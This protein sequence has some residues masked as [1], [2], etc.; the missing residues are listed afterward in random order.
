MKKLFAIFIYIISSP[1]ISLGQSVYMHEA[2]EDARES[3]AIGFSGI[4]S[5]IIFFGII[6]IISKIYNNYKENKEREK[7]LNEER[8]INLKF[9]KSRVKSIL[10]KDKEVSLLQNNKSWQEGFEEAYY[11]LHFGRI[12]QEEKSLL[13]LRNEL[14]MLEITNPQSKYIAYTYPKNER[15]KRRIGYLEYIEYNKRQIAKEKE[16][17]NQK[18]KENITLQNQGSTNFN[19]I[20]TPANPEVVSKESTKST[21]TTKNADSNDKKI[22]DIL[23]T[24][25]IKV[26]GLV[27][28]ADK[29]TILKGS[30]EGKVIVP[31]G[32]EIVKGDAF[33]F[34][35]D[36]KEIVLPDSVKI[37]EDNAFMMT[38]IEKIKMPKYLT[39]LGTGVFWGCENLKEIELSEG[40][41]LL[42]QDTFRDCMGLK[43]VKLPS[44]LISIGEGAFE[45]CMSLETIEIPNG[46][47][48]IGDDAFA[49]CFELKKIEL[50]SS[51][52]RIGLS[53]FRACGELKEFVIPADV[54]GISEYTF[55]DCYNLEK[56]K[57]KGF[58]GCLLKHAFGNCS[59]MT[60][61]MPISIKILGKDVFSQCD[62][63]RIEVPE[64]KKEWYEEQLP[65]YKDR[66]IT[67][68][69]NSTFVE[70]PE[71]NKK[72]ESFIGIH[73]YIVKKNENELWE[74][75]GYKNN[76]ED[77]D[78]MYFEDDDF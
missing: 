55:Y 69:D 64:T 63:I 5:V 11:D 28:S 59:K 66:I 51:V 24:N 68:K 20:N 54:I 52:N 67:Y 33:N 41:T 17:K 23:E 73:D 14:T 19:N 49:G 26:K 50:P 30:G 58:P 35:K 75:M 27:I 34:N 16:L 48:N 45:G 40:L 21:N 70:T 9:S 74:S 6:Y 25:D 65:E 77:D 57:F 72:L 22:N 2:Q 4:I 31:D 32:V 78:W 46:V 53:S 56:V 8:E 7:K 43:Y 62:E 60:I 71:W 10:E 1:I 37:I 38:T 29:K 42:P 15:I 3:G 61:R 44:S 12:K 13:E 47:T 18:S 36:V 39:N 76:Y